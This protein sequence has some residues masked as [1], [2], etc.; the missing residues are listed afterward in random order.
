LIVLAYDLFKGFFP[1]FLAAQCS[2]SPA[3]LVASAAAPV[4]GHNW[5]VQRSFRGGRGMAAAIG[6]LLYLVPTALIPALAV[7]GI[8]A[9]YKR[10]TPW[11]AFVGLP[12]GLVLALYLQLPGYKL[13]TI[14]V[15]GLLLLVR[16]LQWGDWS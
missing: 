11:V 8:I 14:L 13:I 2:A 4:V 12:L 7:G 10:R 6:A 1:V 15:L 16:Q 5:P 3:V 9:V